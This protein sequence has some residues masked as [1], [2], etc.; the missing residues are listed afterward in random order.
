MRNAARN[1]LLVV[2]DT[3]S[4]RY[5]HARALRMAGFDTIEAGTGEQGISLAK[6]ERPELVLLDIKLPDIDGFEVCRRLRADPATA[7]LA[8]V[9]ISATFESAEYQVRGLEGGADMFLLSP[10]EPAVLVANVRAMLRLR[11]AEAELREFDRRKDEFLATVAHELRNPLAPLRYCLDVI[12][13]SPD[14][15]LL[16]RCLGIMRRQT[17]H[18][19]RLVEDLADMSRITQNKLRLQ[20]E[21]VDLPQVLESAIETHRSELTAKEQRLVVDLPDEPLE[22]H[23]DAVRLAQVFGNLLANAVKYTPAGGTIEITVRKES[24]TQVAIAF[25]DNGEGIAPADLARI[26]ELFVQL[27]DSSKGLGIGLALVARLVNMHGG[28]IEAE[29][30][31]VGRGSTFTVRL[32]LKATREGSA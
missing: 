26:F 6:T 8:I 4:S 28:S 11:R 23:A 12:E 15:Q 3:E 17:D 13:G 20:I 21:R 9:Q 1:L 25:R 27:G 32:P 5:V 7:S 30:P 18:L 29:S 10:I 19:V 2:D 14:P 16:E 31:G 22:L 24:P